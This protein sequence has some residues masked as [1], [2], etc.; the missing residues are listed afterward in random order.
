MSEVEDPLKT[1]FTA[2]L[3]SALW[4]HPISDDVGS[5]AL[6]LATNITNKAAS[7]SGRQNPTA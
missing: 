1:N 3:P 2:H 4:P 7:R 6:R 5:P